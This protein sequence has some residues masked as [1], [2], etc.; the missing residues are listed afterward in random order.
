MQLPHTSDNDLIW[1]TACFRGLGLRLN[2]DKSISL[3]AAACC[4]LALGLSPKEVESMLQLLGK[5]PRKLDQIV[6]V[7]LPLTG[8]LSRR[9][10]ASG[11]S[12]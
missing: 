11:R 5:G 6:Q 9:R 4:L 7:H 10:P 8:T 3:Y 2:G 12:R 1:G